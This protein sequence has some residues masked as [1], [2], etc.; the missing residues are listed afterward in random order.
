MVLFAIC[1]IIISAASQRLDT[2]AGALLA[3]L[4]TLP[5]G[6]FLVIVQLIAFG[7][8]RPPSQAGV[9][10]FLLAGVFSTYLGRWLFFRSIETAGPT[11]AASFQTSSPL[12]TALLGWLLLGEQFN[13][14]ALTGIALGV[15]G[16]AATSLDSF[17][18]R[19]NLDQAASARHRAN[20]REIIVI[21]LG[22]S[23]AYAVSHVLRAASVREWNEPL[24]GVALG[25]AA[26]SLALLLVNRRN[27]ISL[28]ARIAA[29][30]AAAK[31]YCVA[32]SMQ[33]T[34]QALMIASMAHIPASFAALITMCTP[35]VVLPLSQALFR[36]RE[37]IG[38]HAVLGM[39][40]TIVGV[41]M[42]ML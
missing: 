14:I 12:V 6:I 18:R 32:G 34:G 7:A 2:D 15:A 38:L 33:L 27:F 5:L 31:M 10:G 37:G 35:L 23:A 17:R 19:G 22:S 40:A 1:A 28:R 29:Q 39:L 41:A 24:A 11:R 3:A 8:L 26:G 20:V 42:M 16:L 9:V 13:P 21:G 4:V 36:N 30:P 25:A